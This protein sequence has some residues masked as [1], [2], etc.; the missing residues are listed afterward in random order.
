MHFISN[1]Y[2]LYFYRENAIMRQYFMKMSRIKQNSAE[3]SECVWKLLNWTSA[4]AFTAWWD[5]NKETRLIKLKSRWKIHLT[6][7]ELNFACKWVSRSRK[8]ILRLHKLIILKIV[9][10]S[11]HTYWHNLP[12]PSC[13]YIFSSHFPSNYF[14]IRDQIVLR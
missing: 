3:N 14:I 9:W 4:L 13:N 12:L 1:K 8:R 7:Q 11:F 2:I 5:L 10:S 6:S